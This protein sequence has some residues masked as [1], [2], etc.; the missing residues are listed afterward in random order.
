MVNL[1]IEKIGKQEIETN[2][3]HL[4]AHREVLYS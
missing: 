4:H 2:E 3:Q 1:I